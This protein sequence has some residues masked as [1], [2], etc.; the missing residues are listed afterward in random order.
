MRMHFLQS[1]TFEST[2]ILRVL[3]LI[4]CWYFE[5]DVLHCKIDARTVV[6]N[7]S[8]DSIGYFMKLMNSLAGSFEAN[9]A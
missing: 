8:S 2:L 6:C 7:C 3:S 9:A 1:I 4:W 5:G